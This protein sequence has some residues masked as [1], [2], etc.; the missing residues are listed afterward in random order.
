VGVMGLGGVEGIGG[1]AGA[2]ASPRSSF[3]WLYI[4]YAICNMQYV[5]RHM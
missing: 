4:L 2:A 5:M 1:V 3:R